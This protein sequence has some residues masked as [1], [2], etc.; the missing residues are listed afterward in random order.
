MV[1]V[2]Q[3]LFMGEIFSPTGNAEEAIITLLALSDFFSIQH[4]SLSLL[5]FEEVVAGFFL[6]L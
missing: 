3:Y 2:I 4:I 6:E 1:I 5:I